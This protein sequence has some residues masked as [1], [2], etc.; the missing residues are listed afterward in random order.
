M[1]YNYDFV[2]E[3][4]KIQRKYYRE[5]DQKRASKISIEEMIK[6][7]NNEISENKDFVGYGY[8]LCEECWD[9]R[10]AAHIQLDKIFLNMVEV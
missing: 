7:F 4:E 5:T 3:L 9:E 6:R 8:T 10:I 1:S 2:K